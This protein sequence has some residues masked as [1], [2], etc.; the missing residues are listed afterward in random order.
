MNDSYLKFLFPKWEDQVVNITSN[1]GTFTGKLQILNN[2]HERWST[3]E[4]MFGKQ[5]KKTTTTTK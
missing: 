2:E 1:S 4:D 3:Q 5:N